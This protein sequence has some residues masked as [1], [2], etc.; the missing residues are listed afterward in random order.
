MILLLNLLP[1]F[2]LVAINLSS[3]V[4][5]AGYFG[6]PSFFINY[7]ALL[8]VQCLIQLTKIPVIIYYASVLH[9]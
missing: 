9:P 1:Y 4:V 6:L 8:A 7:L 3:L 5:P 2:T